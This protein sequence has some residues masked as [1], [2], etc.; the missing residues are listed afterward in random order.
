VSLIPLGC[1][2][3]GTAVSSVLNSLGM[4]VTRRCSIQRP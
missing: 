2:W 1:P 3:R 4:S